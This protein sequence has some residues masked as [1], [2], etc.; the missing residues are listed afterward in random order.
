MEYLEDS[1]WDKLQEATLEA[2][3]TCVRYSHEDVFS[4]LQKALQSSEIQEAQETNLAN[5]EK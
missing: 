5:C 2:E 1:L 3:T 4:P